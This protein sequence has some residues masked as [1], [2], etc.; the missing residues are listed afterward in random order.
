MRI[1]RELTVEEKAEFERLA[2]NKLL[3]EYLETSL[4]TAKTALMRVTSDEDFRTIQG[5]A[6]VLDHVLSSMQPGKR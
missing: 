2:H 4:D 3:R 5:Q 6:Q 1:L